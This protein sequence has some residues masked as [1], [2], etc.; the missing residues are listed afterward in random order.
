MEGAYSNNSS[1]RVKKLNA[2][3]INVSPI[4]VQ[5][6]HQHFLDGA[7]RFHHLL[8]SPSIDQSAAV[9]KSNLENLDS[10]LFRY[11]LSRSQASAVP[12][13]PCKAP[14]IDSPNYRPMIG[15]QYLSGSSNSSGASSGFLSRSSSSVTV[16]PLAA[17]E[18]LETPPSRSP[19]V[20]NT[21]VKIEEDVLVMDGILVGSSPGVRMK[22]SASSDSGGSSSGSNT[23]YKTEICRSW[24]DSSHCRYGS[25]CKFAHGKEE[26]QTCKSYTGSGSC[27]YGSKCRFVHHR[28]MTGSTPSGPAATTPAPA[29]ARS[30]SP[31]KSGKSSNATTPEPAKA[32][33][34][35]PTKSEK[36]STSSGGT[37]RSKSNI[38]IKS[39]STDWC[40]LDDGINV[41]LPSSPS[42]DE[43]LSREA[44]NSNIDGV[45]YGPSR[46]KRLP[47]F[48]K[49]CPE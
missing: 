31:T 5:R 45:L 41:T 34:A 24:E 44:V 29:K 20:F 36:S 14:A 12:G 19:P 39:T 6:D 15:H 47:V 10:S 49:I 18:N 26:A 22:L 4:N 3:N 21:P 8:S 7:G 40:P 32:L 37:G 46:R 42:T 43:V 48:V 11:L 17:V 13:D 23:F 35:S 38:S 28:A 1:S 33:S 16:T 30:A 27:S 25:K 9:D 2:L